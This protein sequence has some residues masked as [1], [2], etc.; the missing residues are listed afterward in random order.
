MHALLGQALSSAALLLQAQIAIP[1]APRG[2]A[3]NAAEVVVDEA[4]VL[5][6]ETIARINR[7]ALDV[8]QKSGGEMAVVTLKD[9]GGRSPEEVALAIGRGWKLGATGEI[10]DR[11]R[12]AAVVILL[13]PKET[14]SDGRGYIRI[15]TARGAEGFIND[16]RAGQMRDEALPALRAADYS[17]ALELITQRVSQR[18]AEEFNFTIDSTLAPPAVTQAP[19]VRSVSIPPALI[20]VLI[21]VAVIV[22]SAIARR[23]GGGA[24]MLPPVYGRRRRGNDWWG[25]GGGFGG[26]GGGGGGGGGFGGFGGGGGFSGGGAGGSW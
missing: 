13:V 3:P 8:K 11:A 14:S 7:L 25:G 4:S 9:L 19:G 6:P 23:Q 1:P 18:F 22:L 26:F 2:Y 10:G 20:F 17:A 15:E 24:V 5:K 21:I 16:A 12:N